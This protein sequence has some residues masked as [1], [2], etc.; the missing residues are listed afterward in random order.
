MIKLLNLAIQGFKSFQRDQVFHF[1]DGH[2]LYSMTGR[3]EVFPHLGAN[4]TGKSSTWDAL[5]WVL[6]GKTLRGMKAGSV[7]NWKKSDLTSVLLEFTK[8]KQLYSVTRSHNPNALTLTKGTKKPKKVTQEYL[9]QFIGFNFESFRHIVLMSQFGNFFFDLSATEKLKVFAEAL[10]LKIWDAASS[11]ASKKKQVA[12]KSVEDSQAEVHV[13]DGRV[14]ECADQIRRLRKLAKTE[15]KRNKKAHQT[16]RRKLRLIKLESEG[17]ELQAQSDQMWSNRLQRKIKALQ[18]RICDKDDLATSIK[19]E[20][21]KLESES[22]ACDKDIQKMRDRVA[23]V[24]ASAKQDCPTC[25]QP[26][27]RHH[28]RHVKATMAVQ[29][30]WVEAEKDK[31]EIK[32][33]N[34]RKRWKKIED[35]KVQIDA[36]LARRED[37]YNQVISQMQSNLAVSR[38]LYG[39]WK[40]ASSELKQAKKAATPYQ[41]ELTAAQTALEAC[42]DRLADAQLA[43]DSLQSKADTYKRCAD[44][45]KTIRLTV[46]DQAI[47]ELEIEVNNSL[48]QLGLKGWKVEFDIE[49]ENTSGGVTKGFNVLIRSPE[50]STRVPWESW[51]GGE[52]QR[53]R[54]A[55]AIGLQSLL[56]NRLGARCNVEVWDEPTTHVSE[57]GISD[58]LD[59][60]SSRARLTKKQIWLVDHRSLDQGR[61]T[62]QVTAVK[63]KLGTAFEYPA[64][65]RERNDKQ[66]FH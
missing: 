46:I 23:T 33:R 45:F 10:D 56:S 42:L 39:Q 20:L 32:I 3:N 47:H 62:A 28:I 65:Q 63:T 40:K 57:E 53:L 60:L 25:Q 11:T 27:L 52:T 22:E 61:F 17:A 31:I 44:L 4:A 6:F 54:I 7:A 21:T 58:L 43:L 36:K 41:N 16:S 37:K 59:F 8:D 12:D 9:E 14:K 1:A 38:S 5:S 30:E 49:R 34:L 55:S 24:S 2:G 15:A 29:I 64:G 26:V 51:S 19:E 18:K 66:S 48:L 13:Q 50:S 35:S